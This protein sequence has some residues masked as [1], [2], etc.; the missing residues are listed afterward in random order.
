VG[1]RQQK[2][3]EDAQQQHARMVSQL[4][5][6][7]NVGG[8]M[9][10][11]LFDRGEHEAQRLA[12]QNIEIWR[13]RRKLLL[14]S[15]WMG[16]CFS[17]L[18]AIGPAAVYGYG[19]W[20]VIRGQ[21]T[22]GVVVAFVAL[23]SGLYAPVMGMAGLFV[24]VQEK[25]G[26]FRRVVALLDD[27]PEIRDVPGA[28][29][30]GPAR[31]ALE[32]DHVT[33][34]YGSGQSPALCDVSFQASAGQLIALVG[35]SGAGKTSVANLLARFYDPQSG[36]VRIDGTDVRTVTQQSL[37]DQIAMVSQDTYLFHDT[38]RANLL[39]A[40]PE[41]SQQELEAACRAA[42]IHDVIASLP[43]GYAT[44]VG[45]RGAKLS[46]GQRQRL[47]IARALLKNPRILILD[48]ATSALDSTSERLIQE[49]L[50]TL[51]R[52]RTTLVIAHR[53]S[54][55]LAADL[56]VVLEHGRV[57]E[58]GTHSQLLCRNGLYARLCRE[59]FTAAA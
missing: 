26:I 20:M 42:Q 2:F 32:F 43:E 41:A 47:A 7:L 37:L 52:G 12:T 1:A 35:P 40:R 17:L 38:L 55:I 6:V 58:T 21:I 50:A 44:M 45:E 19:G 29:P 8:Y 14:S 59:Q 24:G 53:F 48:E 13:H 3:A 51:R 10:M 46:G 54:T 56:I 9:L 30:L 33:F 39:Y 15:R 25:M 16:I 31:G 36:V 49:A 18:A 5:G 34:G 27:E 23:L 28:P 4:H 22:I 11:R 57:V